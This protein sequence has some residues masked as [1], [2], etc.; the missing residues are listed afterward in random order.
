M[1]G[2]GNLGEA[3]DT[4]EVYDDN[5]VQNLSEVREMW[6]EQRVSYDW[7]RLMV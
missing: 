1:D 6:L 3:E 4:A 2:K 7:M 5:E